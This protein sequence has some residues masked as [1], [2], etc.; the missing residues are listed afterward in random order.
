MVKRWLLYLGAL[1]GCVVFYC[2]YRQWFSWFALAA[3]LSLPVFSLLLSLPAMTGATLSVSVPEIVHPGQAVKLSFS[4]KSWAPAPMT[5]AR[6]R[7]HRPITGETWL[8]KEGDSFPTDH[9]G[10]LVCRPEKAAVYDYLGLFRLRIP[11]QVPCTLKL[12]PRPVPISELPS[13]ARQMGVSWRPKAGGGFSEQHEI[14]LYR[15]GDKLNQVHW[16]L[17]AK[18]GKL[19]VREPME[20]A[21]SRV[22]VEMLLRGTPEEL[23]KKFG[24]LLWLGQYLL[25]KGIRYDLRV[26]TGSGVMLL[27]VAETHELEEALDRLLSAPPAGED[28]TLE[29]LYAS[30]Q[31]RI[32]GDRDEA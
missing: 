32:G 28:A 20:P 6:L 17:S 25:G 5:R 9:C 16:K 24:Q 22:Y 12:R 31:Y 23:D 18:T 10:T 29:P 19:M 11:R 26:L 1:I 3:V 8:L 14:R 4:V 27:P 15:P 21:A 7:I 13:L 2:A 30:W